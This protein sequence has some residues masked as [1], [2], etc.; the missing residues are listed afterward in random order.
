MTLL[1][2]TEGWVQPAPQGF[3]LQH[4]FEVVE[5]VN[6]LEIKLRFRKVSRCQLF[7]SVFDAEGR[8]RGTR[9]KPFEAGEVSLEL[10]LAEETASLGGLPGAIVPGTWHAQIDVLRTEVTTP[11]WYRLEVEANGVVRDDIA[12]RVPEHISIPQAMPRYAGAGYYRGELH[13]HSHHSDGT[14]SVAA[15]VAQ[16]RHVGL[17][18]LALT[19]HVTSAGWAELEALAGPDLAV[20]KSLELTGRS[21]HANLHGLAKWV[22]P[23]VDPG[24]LNGRR[25]NDAA[26]EARE[27]GGLFGINHAFCIKNSWR[28]ADLDWSLCDLFEIYHF[29]PGANNLAQLGYWDHLLNLGHR[30]TGVGATDYHRPNTNFKLGSVFTYVYAQDLAPKSLLTGLKAGRAYVSLGPELEFTA[31]ANGQ[32]AHMGGAL[33]V[34]GTVAFQIEL[35]KLDQ[36]GRLFV[37]RNGLPHRS[38]DLTDNSETACLIFEDE[39][40]EPSYYRLEL[41]KHHSDPS[42]QTSRD[43]E[44][45]LLLSNPVYV[46]EGKTQLPLP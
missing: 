4:P 21:G 17:D 25:V 39:P 8:Y 1:K 40:R 16:A 10:G 2:E 28:Y 5:G 27:Q 42:V 23:F 12:L 34:G 37:L 38:F 14:E 15:L 43:W 26:R 7:L 18:F 29:I 30:I 33:P 24:N 36:A 45:T 19:D 41:Y 46:G 35:R 31:T 44:R 6:W 13:A 3:Y 11:T 9:M 22:D 32:V 20:I